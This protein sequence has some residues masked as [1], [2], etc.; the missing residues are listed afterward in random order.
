M[1]IQTKRDREKQAKRE[2]ILETAKTL[3]ETRGITQVTM[4][5]IA[6]ACEYSIGSLY[7]YFKSKDDIYM[8]LAA[9]GGVKLD[10]LFKQYLL[11]QALTSEETEVLIV[12]FLEIFSAYGYY[13]DVLRLTASN[14]ETAEF[15]SETFQILSSSTLSSIMVVT[16]YFLG[17]TGVHD[18][19]QDVA[20]NSTFAAWALLMGL[21]QLLAKGRGSLLDENSRT[22]LIRYTASMFT[23]GHLINSMKQLTPN[24]PSRVKIFEQESATTEASV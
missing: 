20:M 4:N 22:A 19:K 15:S 24:E 6:E 8:G 18:K 21:S 3:F 10:E 5:D 2:R 11:G 9:I 23:D 16:Q 1:T 17:L 12:Q 7:L 14:L 13:F